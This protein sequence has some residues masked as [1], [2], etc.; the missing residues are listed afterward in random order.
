MCSYPPY[1]TFEVDLHEMPL[2]ELT[3]QK[4]DMI[5]TA[6]LIELLDMP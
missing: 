3:I 5:L 6:F 1:V 2:G 4:R